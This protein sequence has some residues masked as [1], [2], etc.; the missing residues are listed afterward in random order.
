MMM[1]MMMMMIIVTGNLAW[2]K[3]LRDCQT[4]HL[5]NIEQCLVDHRW[6]TTVNHLE[7]LKRGPRTFTY[8]EQE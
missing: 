5:H 4:D 3:T 7:F 2:H 1:M 6:I 8:I